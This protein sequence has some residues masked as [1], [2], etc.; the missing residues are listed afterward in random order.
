MSVLR[1]RNRPAI[2]YGEP[3]STARGDCAGSPSI[4]VRF[5]FRTPT[6]SYRPLYRTKVEPWPV[7]VFFFFN[8]KK[9]RFSNSPWN[10]AN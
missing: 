9:F 2:V 10:G 1:S 4:S 5:L 6:R 8:K 3:P 7:L